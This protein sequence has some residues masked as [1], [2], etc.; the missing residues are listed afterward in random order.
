MQQYGLAERAAVSVA[1]LETDRMPDAA[2]VRWVRQKMPHPPGELL[3]AAARTSSLAGSVQVVARSVETALHKMHEIGFDL[4]TVESAVG[5][6]PCPPS[7]HPSAAADRVAMGVCNDAIL[8]GGLVQINVHADPVEVAELGPRIP[9][10]SSPQ[11]GRPFAE[12]LAEFGGDFYRLDPLLFAP[13]EL[14]MRNTWDG[15][16]HRFGRRRLDGYR[17]SVAA[18]RAAEPALWRDDDQV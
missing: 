7:W 15:R 10:C 16:T 13:A 8:L 3:I 9:S 1:I 17:E 4:S 18:A 6:A 11:F 14:L 12:L 2:A 5:I